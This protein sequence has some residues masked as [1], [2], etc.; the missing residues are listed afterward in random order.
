LSHAAIRAA[1]RGTNRLCARLAVCAALVA[2]T[3]AADAGL[4]GAPCN[5]AKFRRPSEAVRKGR[6]LFPSRQFLENHQPESAT[7]SRR[8]NRQSGRLSGAARLGRPSCLEI[9]APISPPTRHMISQHGHSTAIQTNSSAANYWRPKKNQQVRFKS[10]RASQSTPIGH[11]SG[12]RRRW[13]PC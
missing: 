11:S 7:E 4:H 1:L 13:L 6:R 8:A 3:L 9:A 12:N 5:S 10:W 2:R